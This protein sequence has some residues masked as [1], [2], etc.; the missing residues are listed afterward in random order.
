MPD[1]RSMQCSTYLVH[2]AMMAH[3]H[4]STIG[5]AVRVHVGMGGDGLWC[6]VVHALHAPRV[7]SHGVHAR[8]VLHGP[9]H[10]HGEIRVLLPLCMGEHLLH[11]PS[12]CRYSA[13]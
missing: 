7:N 8:H 6:A 3:A 2:H 5:A 13:L 10:T 9:L 4:V 11:A 12:Q 1:T